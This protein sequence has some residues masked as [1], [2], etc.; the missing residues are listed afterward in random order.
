MSPQA[1]PPVTGE[2][3]PTPPARDAANEYRR[4]GATLV[5]KARW[6]GSRDPESA[7]Q[8]TLTRSLENSDS[9]AA[10]SYYFSQNPPDGLNSRLLAGGHAPN[11]HGVNGVFALRQ[12]EPAVR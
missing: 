12:N 7:A 11:E 8:E 3:L 9:R 6:L 1:G 2:R 10:V 5:A 4:L